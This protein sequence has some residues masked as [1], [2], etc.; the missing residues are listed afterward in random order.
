M[1]SII[2]IFVLCFSISS[3]TKL[4]YNRP[5]HYNF[6]IRTLQMFNSSPLLSRFL[7]PVK[8]KSGHYLQK[9]PYIDDSYH[10]ERLSFSS[11]CGVSRIWSTV[12]CLK[13][14]ISA[15]VFSD[16]Y[17]ST[18]H[19]EKAVAHSTWMQSTI[20]TKYGM[21]RLFCN[22]QHG[23]M[24]TVT[25]TLAKLNAVLHWSTIIYRNNKTNQKNG[26]RKKVL[27]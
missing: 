12:T 13:E 18:K 9:I 26:T 22:D 24:G 10:N 16:A 4:A 20:A 25:P 15:V 21:F 27:L 11:V 7:D 5:T 8:L 23:N 2:K 1:K 17:N 19:L 6:S 3:F 14:A